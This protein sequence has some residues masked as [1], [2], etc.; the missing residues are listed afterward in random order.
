MDEEVQSGNS[1]EDGYFLGAVKDNRS[2]TKWSVDLSL[3]KTEM[4][5]KIDTGA[6]MSHSRALVLANRN[7]QSPKILTTTVWIQAI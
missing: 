6:D 1:D 4:R 3:G 7:K 5:F 2:Q